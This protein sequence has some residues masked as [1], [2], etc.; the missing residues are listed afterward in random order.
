MKNFKKENIKSWHQSWKVF[1]LAILEHLEFKHFSFRLTIVANNKFSSFPV[2][3]VWNVFHW[4]GR[5]PTKFNC[6]VTSLFS[7]SDIQILIEVADVVF[8]LINSAST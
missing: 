2:F 7:S 8:L 5:V 4:P 3:T 1:V 6:L